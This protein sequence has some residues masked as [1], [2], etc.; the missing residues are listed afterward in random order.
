M[1]DLDVSKG[2]QHVHGDDARSLDSKFKKAYPTY[3]EGNR[4]A[5][6]LYY[7]KN[8]S[9]KVGP[10]DFLGQAPLLRS[11]TFACGHFLKRLRYFL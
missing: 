7:T 10:G 1:E 2:R 6:L 3:V 8:K 4:S 5:H 11:G 9:L